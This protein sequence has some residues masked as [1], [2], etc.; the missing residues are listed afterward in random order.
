MIRGRESQIIQIPYIFILIALTHKE[1]ITKSLRVYK[2]KDDED[3]SYVFFNT[4]P[5]K[6]QL[7]LSKII[8]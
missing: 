4:F 1:N 5:K 3:E 8:Q 7:I 6:F 2:K